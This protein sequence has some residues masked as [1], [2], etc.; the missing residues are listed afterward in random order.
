MRFVISLLSYLFTGLE[1]LT[2]VL[3][4]PLTVIC[5]LG[6]IGFTV[7]IARDLKNQKLI[8]VDSPQEI[9]RFA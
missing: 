3:V 6:L 5:G 8:D 1:V 9:P 2:S 7:K 4:F